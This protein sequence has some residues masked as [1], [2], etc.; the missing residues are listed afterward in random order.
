MFA[1]MENSMLKIESQRLTKGRPCPNLQPRICCTVLALIN[2]VESR[3][4]FYLDS[5]L[6]FM[7]NFGLTKMFTKP[8]FD[9]MD[10][11]K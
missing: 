1:A 8:K 10:L 9:C 2:Y 3:D 7:N 6:L 5:R 11:L 4:L